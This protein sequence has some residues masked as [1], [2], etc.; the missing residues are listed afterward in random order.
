MHTHSH[1][2]VI[3]L[4]SFSLTAGFNVSVNS[5][6]NRIACTSI[7]TDSPNVTALLGFGYPFT[8]D[9]FVT[10]II[11]SNDANFTRNTSL[12]V[13][14]GGRSEGVFVEG[15]VRVCV[16]GCVEGGV[17]VCV[18]VENECVARFIVVSCLRRLLYLI[19]YY[20]I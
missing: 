18:W 17:R 10:Q 12:C 2:Q 15:G 14:T 8:L 9:T 16:C 13:R 11:P 4:L 20:I 3:A 6:P 19:F 5:S 7:Q 1:V